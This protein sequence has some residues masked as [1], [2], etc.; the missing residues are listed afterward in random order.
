MMRSI[1]SSPPLH[2]WVPHRWVPHRW[3]PCLFGLLF[4]AATLGAE[5]PPMSTA[6]PA[7]VADDSSSTAATKIHSRELT[8][9][10]ARL[11]FLEAGHGQTPTVLL[12]H[13]ARFSAE[14][15]R[16]LG[17]LELLARQGYRA[18]ALDLPGYGRSAASTTP[19]A[20]FLAQL[21][22]LIS[23]E[24]LV[25]VS[26]S[27]SGAYSL[28]VLIRRSSWITGY[29]A[30]APAGIDEHRDELAGSKIA[31]LILWGEKDDIIPLRQAKRLGAALENSRQ[32]VLEGA[33]H[34][35]YLDRPID[36]HRELL[37]F[38]ASL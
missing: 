29:V 6:P 4:T 37:R 36:F 11:H 35:C 10:G 27:M 7:P 20:Q 18:V 17:T 16:Q 25:I 24:P 22:P 38:L 8:L 5:S 34:A 33:G 30:V 12:L 3:I 28:P 19:P 23:D 14:T 32:V 26:P 15:W 2:R 21:I 31:S 9:M 13:G 1:R